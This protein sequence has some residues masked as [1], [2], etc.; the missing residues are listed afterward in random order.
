MP[1]NIYSAFPPLA[2][3]TESF[4][5]VTFDV[6]ALWPV[7]DAAGAEV[8]SKLV[9][10]NGIPHGTAPNTPATGSLL[11]GPGGV[12][13]QLLTDDPSLSFVPVLLSDGRFVIVEEDAPF[14]VYPFNPDGATRLYLR[15]PVVGP[16]YVLSVVEI[17]APAIAAA[18]EHGARVP[19]RPLRA[20]R[21]APRQEWTADAWRAAAIRKPPA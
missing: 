12:V 20:L 2:P 9:L 10:G 8:G 4:V 16:N 3:A 6:V 5:V 7:Y 18:A 11:L 17:G 1:L 14:L 15:A 21:A 19:D 13:A